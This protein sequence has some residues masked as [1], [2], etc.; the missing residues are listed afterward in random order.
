MRDAGPAVLALE[1]RQARA[2]GGVD[3]VHQR[4]DSVCVCVLVCVGVLV[5]FFGGTASEST[6]KAAPRR[7]LL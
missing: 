6:N 2:C 4:E 3:S 1:P 5:R 7:E